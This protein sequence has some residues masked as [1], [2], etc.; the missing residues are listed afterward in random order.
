MKQTLTLGTYGCLEVK[1]GFPSTQKFIDQQQIVDY[2]TYST[3]GEFR[4]YE[5]KS[6]L[7]DLKSKAIKSF[8]GH[9]NYFVMTEDLFNDPQTK[10]YLSPFMF[11]G[12]GVYILKNNNE[13]ELIKKPKKKNISL[14]QSTILLESLV[15]SLF[16]EANKYYKFINKI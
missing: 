12:I 13:L 16:R 6:N 15:K 14:G 2:I 10:T 3:S 7:S 4:C 9:Y 8:L 5:I 1:I 11:N